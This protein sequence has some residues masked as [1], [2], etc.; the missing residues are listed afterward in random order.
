MLL[1]SEKKAN[2]HLIMQTYNTFFAFSTQYTKWQVSVTRHI[3]AGGNE[4]RKS[5]PIY[6]AIG[7]GELN[8]IPRPLY[9]TST[10]S[11]ISNLSSKEIPSH[12][13]PRDTWND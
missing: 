6:L 7:H 13:Y 4:P 3:Y 8:S 10:Y 1:N 2:L 11:G 12:V 5:R 9:H